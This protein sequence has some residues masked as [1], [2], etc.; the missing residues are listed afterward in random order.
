MRFFLICF[1]LLAS[2]LAYG[3]GFVRGTLVK[4]T[5]GYKDIAELQIGDNVTCA[6]LHGACLD[7]PIT[8]IVKKHT[9]ACVEIWVKGAD[10]E[11]APLYAGLDHKFYAPGKQEWVQAKDLVAGN[12]LL[13]SCNNSVVIEHLRLISC[14]EDLYDITV[15][16][17]HN[18]CVTEHDIHVHNIAPLIALGITW[19]FGE[20]L[21]LTGGIGLGAAIF[22]GLLYTSKNAERARAYRELDRMEARSSNFDQ[23]S[24][25]KR[26]S[27]HFDRM[28]EKPNQAHHSVPGKPTEAD[29]FIPPKR[30]DG[31]KVKHPET[32][33]YG[34]PD[35]DGNV[36]VPS[37]DKGHGGPHWDVVYPKPKEGKKHKNILPGGQ[38]R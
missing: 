14:E 9:K 36:W 11:S 12:T 38:E 33:Q 1:Y 28:P 23:V 7:R 26:T 25:E 16:E 27:H 34:W 5:N 8:N 6:D 13:S 22:G 21:T 19:I 20:G 37:G 2:A 3:E 32:G 18:F 31:E 29:G 17:F 30:W 15:E 35:E 10:F 4:A 24:E